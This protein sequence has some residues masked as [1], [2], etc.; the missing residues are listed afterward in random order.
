M[1]V[2]SFDEPIWIYLK[3]L[4]LKLKHHGIFAFFLNLDFD[5]VDG[6]FVY[7]LYDKKDP[8][9]FFIMKMFYIYSNIPNNIFY[10]A[11]FDE[12]CRTAC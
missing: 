2:M 3:E 12:T 5:M 8:F 9:P 4:D 7:K 10:A 6:K 1:T 11:F